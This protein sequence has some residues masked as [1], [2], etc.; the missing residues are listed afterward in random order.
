MPGCRVLRRDRHTLQIGVGDRV[1]LAADIPEVRALLADLRDGAAQPPLASLHPAAARLLCELRD[2]GVVR[3][4]GPLL[5]ALGTCPG[6][7]GREQHAAA[8]LR[9]PVTAGVAPGAGVTVG[10]LDAGLPTWARHARL[11]LEIAGL[12]VTDVVEDADILLLLSAEPIDRRQVDG[13]MRGDVPHLVLDADDARVRLGPFVVPGRSTCLRC[14][15]AYATDQ[16]PHH[17]LLIEQRRGAA[18]PS[19][20]PLPLPHDLVAIAAAMAVRELTTYADGGTPA[21]LDHTIEVDPALEL[22][23]TR[24]GRHPACGC[25][26]DEL[27]AVR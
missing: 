26:W 25:A 2:R 24:W 1:A 10:L 11:L 21:T 16:D 7:L 12:A 3:D 15:D 18:T 20:L 13:W 14:I 23:T 8:L 5:R 22:P 9:R 17:P 19:G 4:S 27:T 6:P